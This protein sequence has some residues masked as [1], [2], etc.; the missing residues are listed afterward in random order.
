[1]IGW[2]THEWLWRTSSSQPSAYGD[3][4]K[5]RQ[6]D[7]RL[8]YTTPD[9][10]LRQELLSQYQVAYIVI[11]AIEQTTY[12]TDLQMDSLVSSGSVVFESKTLKI[13]RIDSP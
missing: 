8:M 11:G 9:Q 4:V 7:V 6:D 2:E 1:M 3:L 10:V 13:I 5:P 12:G